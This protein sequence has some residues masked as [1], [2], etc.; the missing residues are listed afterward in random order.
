MGFNHKGRCVRRTG[1]STNHDGTISDKRG[2]GKRMLIE[3]L[4]IPQH[5]KTTTITSI[6]NGDGMR[7]RGALGMDTPISS[8]KYQVHA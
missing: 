6:G 1:N 7:I 3:D 4:L 2:I 5:P 8:N